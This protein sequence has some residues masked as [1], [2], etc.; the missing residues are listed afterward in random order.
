MNRHAAF[1]LALLCTLSCA[2]CDGPA[3]SM[4]PDAGTAPP[5]T[6]AALP[7]PDDSGSPP[8]D[9]S[10]PAPDAAQPG[11]DPEV[12]APAGL[13]RGLRSDETDVFLVMP[14][15]ASTAGAQRFTRPVA[16]PRFE[17]F[18]ATE[19]SEGC[20]RLG[21]R[22]GVSGDE[23][24]LKLNIWRPRGA[25]DRPVMVFIHGGA[26]VTGNASDALYDGSDLSAEGP[27]VV[28]IDYRIGM[29]GWL[30]SPELQAEAPDGLAGNYGLRDQIRALEWVRD[31]IASFG[32]DPD[33]VTVFG[34]SAGAMSICALLATPSAAGLFHRAIVESA[35]GCEVQHVTEGLDVGARLIDSVGCG[36]AAD[37]L[38]CLRSA[39]I[40][41]LLEAAD[42][43]R[44]GILD[45]PRLRPVAEGSFVLQRSV[46]APAGVDVPLLVGSNLHEGHGFAAGSG[47]ATHADYRAHLTDQFG[48]Q[49]DAVASLYPP[50]S[51]G[52]SEAEVLAV[53]GEIWTD[54]AFRCPALE[55]A[56][57]QEALGSPTYLYEFRRALALTTSEPLAAHGF[58]LFYVFDV[59]GVRHRAGPD[60]QTLSD[61]IQRVWV[62][63]AETGRIDAHVPPFDSGAPRRLVLDV[64]VSTD[65]PTADLDH[66]DAL[67]DL[68]VRFGT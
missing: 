31:N 55:L 56:R 41:R 11:G 45:G 5:P 38:E 44:G 26:F 18:D 1:G 22:G 17:R 61:T 65:D 52:A 43:L 2:A 66:C 54:V 10:P 20:P 21:R 23:D 49:A 48:A 12:D 19:A 37:R 39:P 13:F 15:A 40:D 27:I 60:D 28:T 36:D 9:A 63:L 7:S 34:E 68:G 46:D 47:I 64:P 14:F 29:L 53:V 25:T 8:V 35:A 24:C 4:T 51:P 62:D 42:Q 57:T 67:A 30:V 6:D 16:P 50:V 3:P 59:F 32:G 33:Q 58:E